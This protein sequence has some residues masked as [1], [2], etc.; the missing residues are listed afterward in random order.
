MTARR[1]Y[2]LKSLPRKCTQDKGKLIYD[3]VCRCWAVHWKD[4]APVSNKRGALLDYALRDHE[5][6]DEKEMTRIYNAIVAYKK[7]LDKR[8]QAGDNLSGI[9]TLSVWYNQR[10][11][12]EEFIEESSTELEERINLKYCHCGEP[13]IGEKYTVCAKHLET[14]AERLKMMSI[15]KEIGV[16]TQGQSLQELSK[17]CRQWLSERKTSGTPLVKTLKDL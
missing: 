4:D 8:K 12:D 3:W 13:T 10:V 5:E 16:A 7:Y 11:Y 17:N 14:H 9:Q 2:T 6:L 1:N 15:L